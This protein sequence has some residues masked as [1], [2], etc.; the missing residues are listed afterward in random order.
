MKKGVIIAVAAAIAAGVGFIAQRHFDTP[1]P[2]AASVPATDANAAGSNTVSATDTAT[3]PPAAAIPEMLPDIKLADRDGKMRQLSEWKGK[4]L[5]V[6]YWATWCAPCRREIPLL[7]E[8]RTS[9][10]AT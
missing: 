1:A 9:R 2:A 10:A 7:N 4:P 3:T 8:L 5:M 6:N